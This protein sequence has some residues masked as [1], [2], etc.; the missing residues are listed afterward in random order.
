MVLL[1][2]TMGEHRN[3][4]LA[5]MGSLSHILQPSLPHP[6]Y[7]RRTSRRAVTKFHRSHSATA[8]AAANRSSTSSDGKTKMP[9]PLV[10]D[11]AVI[12]ARPSSRPKAVGT[13]PPYGRTLH[14]AQLI[15][16]EGD[17]LASRRLGIGED[18][19]KR[20]DHLIL[21]NAGY[22]FRA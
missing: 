4:F 2:R 19:S 18:A 14:Q 21:G 3:H 8:A 15:R 11:P 12:P 7:K 10:P 1:A 17:H 20:G 16:D 22:A 6:R 13:P 9:G 5:Q